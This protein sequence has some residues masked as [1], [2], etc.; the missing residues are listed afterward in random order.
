MWSLMQ[1]LGGA[2]EELRDEAW[3][4]GELRKGIQAVL[5]EAEPQQEF[6]DD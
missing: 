5:D 1:A 6:A 4:L 3:I 2:G